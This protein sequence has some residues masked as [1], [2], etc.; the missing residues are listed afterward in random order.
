[1]SSVFLLLLLLATAVLLPVYWREEDRALRFCLGGWLLLVLGMAGMLAIGTYRWPLALP[2][3]LL[4]AASSALLSF[5][6]T[7]LH[8]PYG[9]VAL[10]LVLTTLACWLINLG[11]NNSLIWIN[12]TDK[13]LTWLFWGSIVTT[14][15]AL[16]VFLPSNLKGS[17]I[18]QRLKGKLKD[19][20]LFAQLNL[21]QDW[22]MIALFMGQ[23]SLTFYVLQIEA[24]AKDYHAPHWLG[25]GA[26]LFLTAGLALLFEQHNR[27]NST[28]A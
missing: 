15:A 14:V 6:Y 18:K 22:I 27:T 16:V 5:R 10:C 12:W 28:S 9:Q 26:L 7:Q 3:Q 25:M 23:M 1:M 24:T 17:G 13:V 11:I 4:L 21:K 2:N 19:E 20:P 8:R